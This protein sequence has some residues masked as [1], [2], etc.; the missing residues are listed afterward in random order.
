[1]ARAEACRRGAT[2][3]VCVETEVIR[4]RGA[5]RDGAAVELGTEVIACAGGSVG[6]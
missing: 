1:M 2:G 6:I 5:D 3:W 4:R